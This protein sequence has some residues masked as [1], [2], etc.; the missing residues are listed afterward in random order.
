[1]GSYPDSVLFPK[2]HV[3]SVFVI[4]P[5]LATALWGGAWS[6]HGCG[7]ERVKGGEHSG[8]QSWGQLFKTFNLDHNDP[9]LEIPFFAIQDQVIRLTF[10][11]VF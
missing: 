3:L 1:M 6:G 10:M 5:F 9:D 7:S 8:E 11:P 4:V 2:L